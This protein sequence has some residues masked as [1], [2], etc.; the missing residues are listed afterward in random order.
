[1]RRIGQRQV[2]HHAESAVGS[3][4]GGDHATQHRNVA[5]HDGEAQA[6]M[7]LAVLLRLVTVPRGEVALEDVRQQIGPSFSGV[8]PKSPSSLRAALEILTPSAG[9][10][11]IARGAAWAPRPG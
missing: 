3:I 10:G 11:A 1:M 4:V 2:D 6:E 8:S 7:R 9:S 5:P